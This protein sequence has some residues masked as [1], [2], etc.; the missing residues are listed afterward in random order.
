MTLPLTTQ[1][2]QPSGAALRPAEHPDLSGLLTHFCDRSRPQ[3]NAHPAILAM[4][5]HQRL[6]SILWESQLKGFTTYSGGHPAVCFTEATESG[7]GFLVGRRAY[8]PWG[9][10][11][12]R[13]SVYDAG[14][15]PVWYARPEEYWSL[16][17]L[18]YS[19][20]ASSSLQS[21]AVRLEPVSSDW[22]EEREWRIPLA[23]APE[24]A[25]PLHALR[26]E[27]LLVGDPG[28]SPSRLLWG[29][30][31]ATGAPGWAPFLP[32]ILAGV[33]RLWWNW[34]DGRLYPLPPLLPPLGGWPAPLS[35]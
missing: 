18:C 29:I 7:L 33:P 34:A 4:P 24:A 25:L 27:A 35:A 20:A 15:G 3:R 16:R 32:G 19:G 28:W 14:G 8:H 30:S 12:S 10:V 2:A 21:W 31:P 17:N 22:L 5:A 6:E 9:L 1:L 26:L 23:P 13:Q 11:F